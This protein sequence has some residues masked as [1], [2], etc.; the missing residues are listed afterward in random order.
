MAAKMKTFSAKFADGSVITR[1]SHR[2]YLF[3]WRVR[4]DVDT[5]TWKNYT[6]PRNHSTELTGFS[7]SR[8]TAEAAA[9]PATSRKYITNLQIEIVEAN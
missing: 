1:T 2:N 4:Y 9:K 6:G 5:S 8:R 7:S 3:A